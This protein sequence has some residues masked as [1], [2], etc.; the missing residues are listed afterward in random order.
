MS[1]AEMLGRTHRLLLEQK[2]GEFSS[3][4]KFPLLVSDVQ[5]SQGHVN[6]NVVVK[7]A[8]GT[9][10]VLRQEIPEARNRVFEHARAEYEGS[11]FLENPENGYG[12]RSVEEQRM[13]SEALKKA[14]VLCPTVYYAKDRMQVIEFVHGARTISDLWLNRDKNILSVTSMV[15]ETIVK[16]HKAGMVAGDRW[17]PN[18]LVTT[19]GKVYLVDFDIKIWGPEIKEFELATLMYH[20]TYFLQK[21]QYYGSIQHL[22]SIYMSLLTD[23]K[24]GE[25]YNIEIILRYLLRYAEFFASKESSQP[26]YCWNKPKE[27]IEFFRKLRDSIIRW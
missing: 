16:M 14:G 3:L 4:I 27:G 23:S 25:I 11:G 12:F 1:V 24:T 15:L 20:L 10:F 17:G 2:N 26:P 5:I 19:D 7:S 21:G 8:D 22:E 13:F 9:L 18:E 6:E